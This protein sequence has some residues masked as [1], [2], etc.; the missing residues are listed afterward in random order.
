MSSSLSFEI[1]GMD[2]IGCIN[3]LTFRG[4]QFILVITDYFSKWTEAIPLREV[5]IFN[6]I[7][8]FKHHVI[9][10]FGILY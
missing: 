3:P 1:W 7:K 10:H 6:V 8:F 2:V 4:H 9:Y 5:K